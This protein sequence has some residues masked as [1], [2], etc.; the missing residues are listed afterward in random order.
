MLN[1]VLRYLKI[2]T[3]Y[4]LQV[5]ILVFS[6]KGFFLPILA[7][8]YTT[9]KGAFKYY[10]SMLRGVGGLNPKADNADVILQ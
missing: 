10:V 6:D 1:E 7:Y 8:D 5:K 4:I 2:L 9:F 3:T